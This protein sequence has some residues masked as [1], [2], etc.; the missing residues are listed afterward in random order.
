MSF[1][2][3]VHFSQAGHFLSLMDLGRHVGS[4]PVGFVNDNLRAV[5]PIIERIALRV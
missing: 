3:G 4:W 1:G 2:P 5:I